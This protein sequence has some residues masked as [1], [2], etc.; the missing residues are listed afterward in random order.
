MQGLGGH[1]KGHTS[2]CGMK[3]R[4]DKGPPHQQ[5]REVRAYL[6]SISTVVQSSFHCTE[7]CTSSIKSV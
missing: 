2:P 7:A 6:G 4:H 5:D 1:Q 3:Q